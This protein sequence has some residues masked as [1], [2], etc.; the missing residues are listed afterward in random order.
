M[1]AN[2]ILQI[3]KEKIGFGVGLLRRDFR[4]PPFKI[5]ISSFKQWNYLSET[6]VE[7]YKL[8]LKQYPAFS[9]LIN[10]HT[11]LDIQYY[12]SSRMKHERIITKVLQNLNFLEQISLKL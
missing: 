1:N 5:P 6:Q 2:N 11:T 3:V 12:T 8:S 7:P 4:R 10:I 9:S